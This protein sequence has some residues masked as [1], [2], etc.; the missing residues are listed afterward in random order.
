V[1]I[2][3]KEGKKC[4]LINEY[5]NAFMNGMKSKI[6]HLISCVAVTLAVC[7]SVSGCLSKK[8]SV[9]TMSG[10]YEDYFL[11][12]GRL[13]SFRISLNPDGTYMFHYMYD[14]ADLS[15]DG[16]WWIE[17]RYVILNSFIQDRGCFPV[18][19]HQVSSSPQTDGVRI[20]C[21]N[22]AYQ[23]CLM[24]FWADG[25]S[26]DINSDTINLYLGNFPD[27]INICIKANEKSGVLSKS[28]NIIIKAPGIYR[29]ET[30]GIFLRERPLNYREL[31][32]EKIK[33]LSKDS[34]QDIFSTNATLKRNNN[35]KTR[36]MVE[37]QSLRK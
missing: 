5:N 11:I 23:K 16:T 26:I 28:D 22:I 29:I 8:Y 35:D 36:T 12:Y 30:T 1:F 2:I 24:Y 15:S 6:A 18:D 27:T 10:L 3:L 4:I 31:K 25:D 14:I 19:V 33:I 37:Q 32:Q 7:V 9:S 34:I 17:G 21:D 20:L 13:M